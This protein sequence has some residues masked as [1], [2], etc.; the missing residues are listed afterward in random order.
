MEPTSP[1]MRETGR[2]ARFGIV[3]ATTLALGLLAGFGGW[4]ALSTDASTGSAARESQLS[5][6][7][8]KARYAVAKLELAVREDQLEPIPANHHRVNAAVAA[9]RGTLPDIARNGAARDRALVSDLRAQIDATTIGLGRLMEASESFDLVEAKRLNR[10]Q[11]RPAPRPHRGD[12]GRRGGRASRRVH[13]RALERPPLA[14]RGARRDARDVPP[15]RSCWSPPSWRSCG[16]SGTSTPSAGP[17]S[18][19][20]GTRRRAT[21]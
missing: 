16:S 17:R 13:G 6:A 18:T 5:E 19:G 3:G 20:S 21:A 11:R 1:R 2:R 8:G 14:E 12:G 15:G 9:L 7:Y 4:A 10:V